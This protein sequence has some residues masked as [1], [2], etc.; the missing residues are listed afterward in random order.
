MDGDEEMATGDE[1]EGEYLPAQGDAGLMDPIQVVSMREVVLA[2][3]YSLSSPSH[4]QYRMFIW[5]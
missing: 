5:F 1:E 2:M 4:T 3:V